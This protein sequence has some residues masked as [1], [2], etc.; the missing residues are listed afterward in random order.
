[1]HTCTYSQLRRDKFEKN[2]FHRKKSCVQIAATFKKLNTRVF[3][4][5]I[6]FLQLAINAS[7]CLGMFFNNFSAYDVGRDLCILQIFLFN[8]GKCSSR[9]LR[10]IEDQICLIG[11]ATGDFVDLTH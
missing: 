7:P 9:N 6:N 8:V 10:F 4:N 5:G 1:M 3:N 11:L 2:D